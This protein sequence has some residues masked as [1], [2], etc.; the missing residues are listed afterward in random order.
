MKCF[1]FDIDGTLTEPRQLMDS[2]FANWFKDWVSEH[3]VY[4]VSGSDLPK[5]QEQIPSTYH[6]QRLFPY[7]LFSALSNNFLN[8][9]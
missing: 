4:L 3:D 5:I 2:E 1:L 9:S 8:P 7:Y 6:M